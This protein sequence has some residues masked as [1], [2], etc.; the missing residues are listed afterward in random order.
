MITTDFFRYASYSKW[1]FFVWAI[2]KM[3]LEVIT[4]TAKFASTVGFSIFLMGIFLG[5]GSL[6][7]SDRLIEKSK[8]S[9]KK[10]FKL[11]LV[12]LLTVTVITVG[13]SIFLF[14]ARYVNP[15]LK[16]HI[17]EHL[18]NVAYGALSLA[19]GMLCTIKQ[20]FDAYHNAHANE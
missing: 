12:F 14:S 8:I 2:V 9:T 6:H 17:I 20:L 7:T 18:H 11:S 4:P 15:A 13:N 10:D 5:L 19:L 16:P 1:L 3:L